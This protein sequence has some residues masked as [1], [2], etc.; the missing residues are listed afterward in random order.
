MDAGGGLVLGEVVGCGGADDAGAQDYGCGC[1]GLMLRVYIG[2]SVFVF[3]P[4]LDVIR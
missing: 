4:F 1:H 2:V 3:T